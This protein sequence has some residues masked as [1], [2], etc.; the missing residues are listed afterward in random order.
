[1]LGDT[2]D[3]LVLIG[4]AVV[5]SFIGHSRSTSY[6][7]TSLLV[8]VLSTAVW[9]AFAGRPI[10][11][12]RAFL[13]ADGVALLITAPALITAAGCAAIIA[14]CVGLFFPDKLG[15]KTGIGLGTV[16]L[17]FFF[18]VFLKACVASD[19]PADPL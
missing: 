6:L 17:V 5:M 3:V 7:R 16:L 19:G 14:L 15:G 13:R 12:M 9:I 8:G 10:A 2:S 4:T 11:L 1:M 18:V